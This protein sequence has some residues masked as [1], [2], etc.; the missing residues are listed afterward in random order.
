MATRRSH[1]IGHVGW[2]FWDK[3]ICK[4]IHRLRMR[5]FE[6]IWCVFSDISHK[7]EPYRS[8]MRTQMFFKFTHAL[9]THSLHQKQKRCLPKTKSRDKRLKNFVLLFVLQG[10]C[11]RLQYVPRQ[12]VPW[13]PFKVK[14]SSQAK[15][16]GHNR[17]KRVENLPLNRCLLQKAMKTIQ[18]SAY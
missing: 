10:R 6:G 15:N 1:H 12:V 17:N 2:L 8:K 4:S 3:S 14:N 18:T 16:E 9:E 5:I 11:P 7:D 13:N